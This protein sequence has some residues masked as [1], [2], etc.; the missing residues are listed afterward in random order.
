[1]NLMPENSIL[2]NTKDA[3]AL[4]LKTGELVRMVSDSNPEGVWELPNFGQK[5]VVGKVQVT[6]GIRPGVITFSLGHGHW[7]YGAADATLDGQVIAGDR[8]RGAGVHGNAVMAVDPHLKN[9]ALQDLVGG[10]VSFYD[11][12][13][14]LVKEP[15]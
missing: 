13:V 7:A 10:S 8:K 3:A 15:T 4:G 6:E 9:V 11:S 12:P 14:R 5:A 2:V 1:M